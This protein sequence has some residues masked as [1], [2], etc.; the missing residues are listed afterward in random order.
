MS[1]QSALLILLPVLTPLIGSS[2]AA[3]LAQDKWPVWAND[4]IAWAI[5]LAFAG[6]DMYA[7]SQFTGGWV[8]IVADG[9]QVVT[10]LASG[11][12]VKLGPWLIWLN[13]L[14][15]NIFNLV[16]LFE[17][18]SKSAPTSTRSNITSAYVPA[19]STTPTIV[20]SRASQQPPTPPS[21]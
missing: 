9:V 16:P 15:T 18:A 3:I 2:V 4:L 1:L 12:L 20:P 14:Q 19:G 6:G 8:L 10:F 5:L 11:W 7:N 13:F 21:A 17:Q